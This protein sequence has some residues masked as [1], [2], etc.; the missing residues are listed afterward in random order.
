MKAGAAAFVLLCLVAIYMG[1][2][3]YEFKFTITSPYLWLFVPDCPL[4]VL[5]ALVVFLFKARN[6]LIGFLTSVG[7]AK[8][9]LWTLFI[10]V[11]YPEV[12]FSG[13]YL[14]D[15]SILVAGHILMVI[16]A[17]AF[18]PKKVGG[19]ELVIVFGWFLLNDLMDYGIGTAPLIPQGKIEM[20]ALFSLAE[21]VILLFV[22]YFFNGLRDIGA[23][24]WVR[25]EIGWLHGS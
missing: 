7:L 11:I 6:P 19:R 2:S 1:F 9:G 20:V 4:Y 16:A 8:Y 12:Y 23:A 3:I 14:F 25:K 24:K 17:L 22:F 10:F 18:L 15:T 13:P 21:T 5:I